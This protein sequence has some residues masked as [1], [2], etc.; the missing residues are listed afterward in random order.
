MSLRSP[1]ISVIDTAKKEIRILVFRQRAGDPESHKTVLPDTVVGFGGYTMYICVKP[2][3]STSVCTI[4]RAAVLVESI[5]AFLVE[6][7]V[8]TVG[9]E[10]YSFMS[11]PSRG[12]MQL[13]ELGGI[14]K[15]ALLKREIRCETKA[16]ASVKKQFTG[17]GRATKHQ[18]LAA[19]LKRGFPDLRSIF[20]S[21]STKTLR[22]P[23]TDIV[24]AMAISIIIMHE[25]NTGQ[26]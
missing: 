4:R 24:D 15:Y 3:P 8:E 2:G 20:V 14:L 18:M 11:A 10:G 19:Y 22:T 6:H 17:S 12:N 16:P 1:G 25:N 7:R 21:R 13:K 9:L 26:L 23:I 5:C